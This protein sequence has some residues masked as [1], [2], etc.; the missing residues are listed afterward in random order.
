MLTFQPKASSFARRNLEIKLFQG[1]RRCHALS[2]ASDVD[3]LADKGVV[4]K[5]CGRGFS[6]NSV[7]GAVKSPR[8]REP[9]PR[10]MCEARSS[11][12]RVSGLHGDAASPVFGRAAVRASAVSWSAAAVALREP[13]RVGDAH[14]TSRLHKIR[15]TGWGLGQCCF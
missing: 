14:A 10:M 11:A 4:G 3:A 6:R 5:I 2:D 13:L 9:R 8:R 15:R 7:V 1:G 12:P